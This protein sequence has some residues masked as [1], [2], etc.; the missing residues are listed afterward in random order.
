MTDE[1]LPQI[2]LTLA[3]ICI[4]AFLA[5]LV[6]SELSNLRVDYA[7]GLIPAVIT[8]K[9]D[10]ANSVSVVPDAATLATAL[11]LHSSFLHLFGNML[12]LWI[13]GQAMEDTLGG[14]R[15][16]LFYLSCGIV[17]ALSHV[18]NDPAS[19][20]PMIGAS[21][22]I[23]GLLGGFLILHPSAKLLIIAPTRRLRLRTVA[24]PAA[25]VLALWLAYQLYNFFAADPLQPNVAWL[26]HVG[27]FFAGLILAHPF[28]WTKNRA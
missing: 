2:T 4:G 10:L 24:V 14:I 17:A 16:F 22:A 19:A 20:V 18:A 11:F 28:M 21:G 9:S 25:L 8:G 12:Y 1:R 5:R 13:F 3:L 27:G 23:S 26:A 7:L 15:F 6:I